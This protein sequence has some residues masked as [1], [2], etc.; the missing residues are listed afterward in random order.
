MTSL[1]VGK[2]RSPGARSGYG[3]LT[4]HTACVIAG[5][6]IDFDEE[7][8]LLMSRRSWRRPWPRPASRDRQC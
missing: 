2:E 1:L 7:T 4:A 6:P 8:Q 5:L 3:Q